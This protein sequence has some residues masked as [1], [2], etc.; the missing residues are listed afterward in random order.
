[1]PVA[2]AQRDAAH[3]RGGDRAAEDRSRRQRPGD[4]AADDM[5]G[6]QA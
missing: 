2:A 6:V 3:G 5:N 1:M 4:E